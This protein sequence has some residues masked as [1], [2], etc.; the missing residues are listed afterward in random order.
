MGER[1][2]GEQRKKEGREVSVVNG[3]ECYRQG[4]ACN[5]KGYFWVNRV[6]KFQGRRV[7]GDK[8]K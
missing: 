7:A 6:L 4:R 2:G 8:E 1:T 3:V 5:L